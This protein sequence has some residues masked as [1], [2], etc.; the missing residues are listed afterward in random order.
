MV[1]QVDFLDE[2]VMCFI[3]LQQS[4]EL[5]DLTEVGVATRFIFVVLG[6]ADSPLVTEYEEMGR[7]MATMLTDKVSTKICLYNYTNRAYIFEHKIL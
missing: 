2:P 7:A 6:P 5:A 4:C 1:G 3:R